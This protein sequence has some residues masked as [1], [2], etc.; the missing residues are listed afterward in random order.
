VII[1]NAKLNSSS[2]IPDHAVTR[3][4]GA[5][6]GFNQLL[7]T[8]TTQPVQ[9]Q[10]TQEARAAS[11]R[12]KTND[13]DRT[14]EAPARRA[15]ER[16][17]AQVNQPERNDDSE[18]AAEVAA[19][20]QSKSSRDQSSEGGE[21]RQQDTGSQDTKKATDAKA[22]GEQGKT[23]EQAQV[24]AAG[25]AEEV[26]A[27]QQTD[28]KAPP[29]AEPQATEQKQV[30]Q[31]QNAAVQ[32]DTAGKAAEQQAV[33]VEKV[34]TDQPQVEQTRTDTKQQSQT[35]QI[36]K[37]QVAE[38]V[39]AHRSDTAQTA[40]PTQAPVQA[41]ADQQSQ[42]HT[43][44]HH[45]SQQQPGRQQTPTPQVTVQQ[46][47]EAITHEAPAQ[48]TLDQTPREFAGAN[49]AQPLVSPRTVDEVAPVR[50]DAIEMLSTTQTASEGRATPQVAQAQAAGPMS[51][52]TEIDSEQVMQRALNGI[53][54]A[55][56]QKG[57][58]VNLRLSP[59]ELGSLRIQVR[60]ANGLVQATF[61][62]STSTAGNLLTEH[63]QSLRHALQ[64]HGLTVENLNVQVQQPQN[65]SQPQ[66][67]QD[68][69]QTP[70]D[71]RSRG[72]LS[73][74]SQG[75]EHRGGRDG[76]D[77]PNSFQRELLDLVA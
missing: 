60:M 17:D 58:T 12:P 32:A 53:R 25:Q 5:A 41:K 52:L 40:Q 21:S 44:Q 14:H 7:Q 20:D 31:A 64:S 75:Q 10:A 39:Q 23:T 56:S 49:S 61:T 15:D 47:T 55:V 6:D 11:D 26:K 8:A 65:S 71:G 54:G 63:M 48:P 68:A 76:Q 66:M 37:P 4:D 74:G 57:G 36:A 77:E 45:Q 51:N 35:Q 28:A 1:Q 27:L 67:Q 2:Y 22:Q 62:A 13:T 43:D 16:S 42:Q 33:V 69:Q 46:P 30:A 9:A 73:D 59:P 18:A 34:K 70:D 29:K 50:L 3:S 19:A 38:Q 72:S 24:R